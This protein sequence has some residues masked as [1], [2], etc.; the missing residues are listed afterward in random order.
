MAQWCYKPILDCLTKGAQR[1]LCSGGVADSM[2]AGQQ[3]HRGNVVCRVGRQPDLVGER[4][5]MIIPEEYLVD[6]AAGTVSQY[7]A[8]SACNEEGGDFVTRQRV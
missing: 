3:L 7:A 1:E 5:A 8:L 2:D 4:G 6:G